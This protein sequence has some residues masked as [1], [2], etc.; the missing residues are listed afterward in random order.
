M[1]PRSTVASLGEQPVENDAS[2]AELLLDAQGLAVV[3]GRAFGEPRAIRISYACKPEEL[4]EGLR[5]F[6]AFVS[7]LR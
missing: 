7:A 1:C 3:P 2:F 4:T 6:E 5:R